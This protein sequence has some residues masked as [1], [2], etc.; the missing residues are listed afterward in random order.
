M[1]LEK[2]S[3]W[4]SHPL[5]IAFH[6]DWREVE[7]GGW[8]GVGGPWGGGDPWGWGSGVGSHPGWYRDKA[9]AKHGASIRHTKERIHSERVSGSAGKRG[10]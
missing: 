5:G 8:G 1:H 10:A 7:W 6:S 2:P 4:N 9:L 3:T